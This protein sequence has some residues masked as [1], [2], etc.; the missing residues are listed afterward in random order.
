MRIWTEVSTGYRNFLWSW[1]FSAILCFIH[2]V[3]ERYSRLESLLSVTNRQ[4][5][6][7][8]IY[9]RVLYKTSTSLFIPGIKMDLWRSNHKVTAG[10]SHLALGVF[11]MYLV[12]PLAIASHFPALHANEHIYRRDKGTQCF[13]AQKKDRPLSHTPNFLEGLND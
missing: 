9:A 6:V 7:I 10:S 11:N 2:Q 8:Y 3:Y 12:L 1:S 4:I 5:W 13:L